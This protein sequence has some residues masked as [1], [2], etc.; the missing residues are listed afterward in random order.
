MTSEDGSGVQRGREGGACTCEVHGGATPEPEP[1][2]PEP[3]RAGVIMGGAEQETAHTDVR[4]S[5]GVDKSESSAGAVAVAVAV[6]A[7][8]AVG[9]Q[10][11]GRLKMNRAERR[12]AAKQGKRGTRYPGAAASP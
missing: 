12:A 8:G 3:P 11:E 5:S 1:E 6:A 4:D 9:G 10:Q 2:Q 7:D